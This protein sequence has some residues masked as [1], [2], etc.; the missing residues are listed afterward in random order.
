MEGFQPCSSSITLS[1]TWLC[2]RAADGHEHDQAV[3][4]RCV[5]AGALLRGLRRCRHPGVAGV[6]DHRRLQWPRR[7]AREK[8]SLV[9]SSILQSCNIK[10]WMCLVFLNRTVTHQCGLSKV[11]LLTKPL[12]RQD[13]SAN[14]G[15]LQACSHASGLC[16]KGPENTGCTHSTLSLNQA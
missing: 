3:G 11:I 1:D 6:L 15:C 5:R 12:R 13:V 7:N 2:P 4:R 10:Q 8:H 14:K 9:F 16:F